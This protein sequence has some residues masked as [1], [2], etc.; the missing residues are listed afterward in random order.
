MA[1]TVTVNPSGI[2]VYRTVLTAAT[3]FHINAGFDGQE[4]TVIMQQDN[5]GTWVV[6]A[7]SEIKHFTT[8]TSTANFDT[9]YIFSYDALLGFWT[10][11]ASS[12][13]PS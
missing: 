9:V 4:L 6:T 5:T 1:N 7:G 12:S 11:Q 2:G 8:P 13:L 10:V 3:T